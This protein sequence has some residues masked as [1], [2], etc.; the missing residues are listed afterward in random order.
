MVCDFCHKHKATVHLS[1]IVDGQTIEKHLCREC[2]STYQDQSQELSFDD[3]CNGVMAMSGGHRLKRLL[4]SECGTS[5][6]DYNGGAP[7]CND[8][9][10][11]F[12]KQLVSLLKKI[13]GTKMSGLPQ[14]NLDDLDRVEQWNIQMAAA[15]SIENYELAAELRDRIRAAKKIK[16][17]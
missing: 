16:T 1:E 11:D 14:P 3:L 7:G 9:N 8:C 13:H 10:A 4:C 6:E 5:W 17:K 12:R 15:I 2:A